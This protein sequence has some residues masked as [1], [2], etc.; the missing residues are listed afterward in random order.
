MDENNLIYGLLDK[1]RSLAHD[2]LLEEDQVYP[3]AISFEDGRYDLIS[4][5]DDEL[6]LEEMEQILFDKLLN[7]MSMAFVMIRTVNKLVDMKSALML[8]YSLF[9]NKEP[10]E[11][12]YAKVFR[13]KNT[14]HF[15]D[16]AP[17]VE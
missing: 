10:F 11:K 6:S 16:L 13:S 7:S 17:I 1:A 15:G 14:V 2:I 3:C 9:V 5:Y 8:E 4:V 12:V